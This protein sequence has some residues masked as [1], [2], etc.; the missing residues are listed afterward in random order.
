MAERPEIDIEKLATLARINL[1]EEEKAAYTGQ[2]KDI[3]G[4]FRQL[5]EID[6][7]G[8]TPMAHPF[9]VPAPLRED[10]PGQ[11]WAPEAALANAPARREDQVVVP[12]VVEDA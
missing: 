9:A 6:V 12:K 8:V 11:P 5:Q 7:E 2:L 3:L 4:F 1:T 10:V